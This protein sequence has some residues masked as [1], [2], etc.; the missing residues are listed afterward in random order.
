MDAGLG[1]ARRWLES[2]FSGGRAEQILAKLAEELWEKSPPQTAASPRGKMPSGKTLLQW[3][4][5][6]GVESFSPAGVRRQS[7]YIAPGD[8]G[9]QL[10]ITL[11]AIHK[12]NLERAVRAKL[13]S[14]SEYRWMFAHE[15]GH[16][17]FYD[18]RSSRPRKPY[19]ARDPEEEQ[20]CDR[21]ASELLMPRKR[22]ELLTRQN[23]IQT[24][25]AMLACARTFGAPLVA[26]A[27]R[28][29]LEL[30]VFP[31][32]FVLV[33]PP[34]AARWRRN[35]GSERKASAGSITT[36]SPHNA[37][38]TIEPK[39]VALSQVVDRLCVSGEYSN[40]ADCASSSSG[41]AFVEATILK[42][43]APRGAIVCLFHESP[44]RFPRDSL[45]DLADGRRVS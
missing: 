27:R 5:C 7:I 4:R 44:P 30:E 1:L 33:E 37:R 15:L 24:L 8:S 2:E 42:T 21:F 43:I 14:S 10:Y 22:V 12:A 39:D 23:K 28:L 16:T 25:E 11:R 17:Y 20:L 6:R 29:I 9:F 41:S 26:M 35:A 38:L 19:N 34:V 45:F 32:T 18:T 36:L 40:T 3:A 31:A 13:E